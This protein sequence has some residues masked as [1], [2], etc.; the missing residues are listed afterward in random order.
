[1]PG[2][3]FAEIEPGQSA[4]KPNPDWK[5][6]LEVDKKYWMLLGQLCDVVPR[7]DTGV[8]ASNMAFLVKFTVK[9]IK[10][11]DKSLQKS[12]LNSGRTG[13]MTVGDLALH[14]DFR[15]VLSA[16]VAAL[17]LCS[18]NR[19]GAAILKEGDTGG[20]VWSLASMARAKQ[21]MLKCFLESKKVPK[22]LQYY[23]TSFS[24]SDSARQLSK[25]TKK[26]QRIFS[27][28]VRRVCRIR[29]VEASEALG[30]MERYWRRPAKPNYFV[31]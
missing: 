24:E 15:D 27:Y 19:N 4:E 17:Q 26:K 12:Q 3:V 2:D 5:G 7:G 25:K 9:A 21:I 11:H 31:N 10:N 20:D 13:W 30:A 29:D 18:F 16:N 8:S 22:E 6:E 23:G 1:V 14:F 28:A